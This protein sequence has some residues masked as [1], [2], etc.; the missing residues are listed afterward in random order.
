MS[1]A[2]ARS[3]NPVQVTGASLDCKFAIRT[4]NYADRGRI[5]R[6][7]LNFRLILPIA[8]ALAITAAPLY[9]D[10]VSD[11]E[12][13]LIDLNVVA[14]DSHGLPVRDLTR[15]D[16]QVTDAGKGQEIAF[17]H[18]TD[19]SAWQSQKLAPNEFSNRVGPKIPYATVILFDLMNEGFGGRGYAWDQI[20]HSL[21]NLESAD[22]LYLYLLTVDGKLFVVHGLTSTGQE[23]RMENGEP[24]SR[25]IK[26]L[27]DDAM[28]KV[29]GLRPLDIDI[30]ARVPLTFQALE[31]LAIHLSRVP[32]RKNIIWVTDGVPIAL[33]PQR[34][35]TG[36]F[37]DFT[38][39]IRTVSEMLDRSGVSIYP[40]R[41]VIFG[42]PDSVGETSGTGETGGEGTGMESI[43][44]LNEIADLTGGRP[45]TGKGIAAVVAQAMNDVRVSYQ[46]GYYAPSQNWDNKFHKIRVTCKRKGVKIEAKSGYYAWAQTPGVRS[47][48]AFDSAKSLAFD[49]AEIG[50][51]A[52]VSV[53][54][55]DGRVTHFDLRIDAHDI[56]LARD[57]DDYN[58]QLRIAVVNYLPDGHTD[59]EG[60]IPL[61]LHF[62]AQ[63]RDE[64]LKNG[65]D[66][67]QTLPSTQSGTQFRIIVFDRGSNAVGSLTIPE[68]GNAS[69]TLPQLNAH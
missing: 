9:G 48:Q 43:Q 1:Q 42:G 38:Q 26:P 15:A 47:Q 45:S 35:D 33:G 24:W 40:V 14:V 34:S 55:K 36:D 13:R 11:S 64:A 57:G 28:Q 56:A 27:L 20:I 21:E 66:F 67:A 31:S 61:N 16:F 8:I 12:T 18:H 58:G 59:S 62:S 5:R 51:R 69:L 50:L 39:A 46:M 37:V 44:T 29:S 68:T 49:E 30:A 10:D 41:Q 17:F 63:E 54:P 23:G 60:A 4:V 32:G 53:N 7:F 25:K 65:I 22:Y 6:A 52:G 3:W 19:T 2:Q